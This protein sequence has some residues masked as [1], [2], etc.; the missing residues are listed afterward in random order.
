MARIPDNDLSA[1]NLSEQEQEEL[2]ALFQRSEVAEL[3]D[4]SV[5]ERFGRLISR[6]AFN[7]TNPGWYSGWA[8]QV[9]P[10]P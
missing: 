7:P 1:G 5:Y 4:A 9:Q 3:L 6:S 8:D 10:R 2:W